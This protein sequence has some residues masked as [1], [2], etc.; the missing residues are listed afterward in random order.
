CAM[1]LATPAAI[2]AGTNVAARRGILIRDGAALEKSGTI[3]AIVF[4]KTGTLTQG[5]PSVEAAEDLRSGSG[6]SP[7]GSGTQGESI[8]E[9]ADRR[10]ACPTVA[11][12]AAA[13][14]QPS[15]HPLSQ[16]VA[17]VGDRADIKS[18]AAGDGHRPPL[19]NWQEL[20][21]KG[22]QASLDGAVCRLGSLN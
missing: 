7:D 4:D 22:V 20:R 2:M 9:Q 10:D 17:A 13:L 8:Q 15:N 18:D 12:L 3:T 14:A 21:G 1:G 16:A 6:V 19:Q 5:K 11:Q